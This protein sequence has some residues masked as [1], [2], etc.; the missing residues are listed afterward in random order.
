MKTLELKP[1][2]MITLNDYPVHSD[3]VLIEYFNQ[4]KKGKELPL[5]PVI[6]KEIVKKYLDSGLVKKFK[7][8]EKKNPQAKY[9]MLDGSHRTTA[10]TLT[11][12]MIATV[13]Y[14]RTE[15]ITEARNLVGSGKI[16]KD[17]VLDDT[18]EENCEVLNK[19]F[20]E[21]PYFM[22]VEEKAKKMVKENLIPRYMA[23]Y[24]DLHS[25]TLSSVF[26]K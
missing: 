21:K 7:E 24:Y 15:D 6:R 13:V 3:K 20:K 11:G 10:L 5:V 16:L 12:R 8:F 2:Q 23:D 26:S 18:L 17:G 25:P 22:T 9:F 19:H 1:N 14:E 4:C